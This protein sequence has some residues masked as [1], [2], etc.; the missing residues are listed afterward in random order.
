MK[1]FLTFCITLLF[2]ASAFAQDYTM[3]Q[4]EN[5]PRHHEW[6][7]IE[8]ND[9]TLHNFVVYPETS[10]P[11]PVVIVIHENR[12]LNGW[13]RSFADQLAAKGFIAVAP[14]LISNT[15]EGIEK[16]SDFETSDAARQAIYSLDPDHVTTD[17]MN[18]LEY[19]KTI[20]AGDGTFAVTGFCWGGSQSFRFATNA[21]DAIDAAFVFYGTG[22]GNAE[23]Y[24]NI[25]VPVYG[26]YGGS[27]ERV[28]S[29]IPDSEEAMNE[30]DK[31]YEYEI[32]EGAGHAYM[33]SGDD[34]EKPADDPN[35]QARNNSWDRLVSILNSLN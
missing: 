29:T 31:T 6:V 24:S 16:T 11:A 23:A 7:T 21:G 4:L 8:S 12:G 25:E 35:V 19:A 26:Y 34:P 5:S 17:L 10:E 3:D 28:N 32:Y 22:P 30:Y 15:V 20:K 33:R 9:R 2:A 1:T 18:V 14:D 13:A 27:D